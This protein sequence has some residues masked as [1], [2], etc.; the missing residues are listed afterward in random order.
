MREEARRQLEEVSLPFWLGRGADDV[1]GGVHTCFDNRGTEKL[2][3]DKYT[4]SQ[5]RWAWMLARA[6]RL[7][8]AGL[9]TV[10][11]DDLLAR[12]RRTVDF[13]LEHAPVGDGTCHFVVADDGTPVDQPHSVYADLFVV[14]GAAEVA[15]ATGDASLLRATEP[16]AERATADVWDHSC[17]TPPYPVPEG[18]AALGP[19]MILLN[20]LLVDAQAREELGLLDEAGRRRLETALERTVA[21]HEPGAAFVEM[22]PG[23]GTDDTLIARHRVPGHDL[24]AIWIAIEA[25]ELLGRD[26]VIHPLVASVA[27]L[28][29]LG[30]DDE[31]EG[32][33]RYVDRDGGAPGG[34]RSDHPYEAMVCDTWDTKLW[35]VHT[36][37][38]YATA[39][40]AYR[41]GDDDARAWCERVWAYTLATFPDPDGREWIQIRDREGAPLEKQVALPV[42]DPFHI[43]RAMLQLIELTEAPA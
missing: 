28:C 17:D 42:K 40:A 39:L 5:G 21:H 20:A 41:Y 4:W 12:A 31:H 13:L 15:R 22:R 30:W 8:R 14:M 43:A 6:A 36:E 35:W 7:G 32:L 16:I 38:S 9:V 27:P 19:E 26:D 34:V 33:F 25:A 2:S 29:A 18:H 1:H 24:E 3:T 10:D 23:D 11:A 37:A